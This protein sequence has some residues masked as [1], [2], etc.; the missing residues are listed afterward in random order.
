MIL[1]MMMMSM[2][3]ILMLLL[4]L[5]RMLLLLMVMVMMT[6][7]LLLIMMMIMIMIMMMMMCQNALLQ[8]Y[9][10]YT[11]EPPSAAAQTQACKTGPQGA[12][13]SSLLLCVMSTVGHREEHR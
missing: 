4:M 13:G 1:L 2:M 6:M 8:A 5:I 3:M 10:V 11:V 9:G 7:L 12:H